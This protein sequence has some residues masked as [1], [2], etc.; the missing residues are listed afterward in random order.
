M[1]LSPTINPFNVRPQPHSPPPPAQPQATTV[2]INN[3][4]AQVFGSS[5]SRTVPTSFTARPSSPLSDYSDNEN[6]DDDFFSPILPQSP[7][8]RNQS[9]I[10]TFFKATPPPLNSAAPA[11]SV[12]TTATAPTSPAIEPP[13]L[14]PQPVPNAS[15]PPVISPPP[16]PLPPQ[17]V[18]P[19]ATPPPVIAPRKGFFQSLID[20]IKSCWARFLSLF[21]RCCGVSK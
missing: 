16:Q 20:R 2:K 3:I 13:V 18:E 14:P 4:A 11:A 1:Q 5:V 7:V 19:Q 10:P 15:P 17:S 21:K 12:A 6:E 8:S 9:P